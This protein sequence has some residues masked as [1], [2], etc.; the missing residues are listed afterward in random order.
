VTS[1]DQS[2][3]NPRITQC[4]VS[5]EESFFAPSQNIPWLDIPQ[6][7]LVLSLSPAPTGFIIHTLDDC[8][9]LDVTCIFTHQPSSSTPDLHE[10]PFPEVWLWPNSWSLHEPPIRP[11]P[12]PTD[13]DP[14]N[15]HTLETI[16]HTWHV[17]SSSSS[18]S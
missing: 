7:D 3:T 12:L 5:R 14:F 9:P 1:D 10:L 13:N 17:A 4:Y 6:I 11:L 8:P 18:S 2:F 15:R 16:D